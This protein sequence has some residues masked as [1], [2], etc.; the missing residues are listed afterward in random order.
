M[1]DLNY[2]CDFLASASVYLP[3]ISSIHWEKSPWCSI[4]PNHNIQVN[5]QVWFGSELALRIASILL[6]REGRLLELSLMTLAPDTVL[7]QLYVRKTAGT[8]HPV[9]TLCPAILS[10][11]GRLIP[12]SCCFLSWLRRYLSDQG[13]QIPVPK[14]KLPVL[15]SETL[16]ASVE[17]GYVTGPPLYR[18][19]FVLLMSARVVDKKI[20]VIR[21]EGNPD[22]NKARLYSPCF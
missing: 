17:Y 7:C 12:Y 13:F 20:C 3:I 15:T 19:F 8:V 22:T 2:N 11:T 1:S 4:T 9:S 10:L 5:V 21:D 16:M 14:V 6:I 18:S